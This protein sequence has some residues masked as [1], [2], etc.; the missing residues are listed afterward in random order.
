MDWYKALLS[1]VCEN[2]DRP[3]ALCSATIMY[4]QTEDIPEEE[5]AV[6]FYP[7]MLL[8]RQ[9]YVGPPD[10][11]M[12]MWKHPP[13]RKACRS[14]PAQL[15][16]A[17]HTPRSRGASSSAPAT[18]PHMSTVSSKRKPA[19]PRRRPSRAKAPPAAA[20]T[21]APATPS[22][23]P[24][25]NAPRHRPAATTATEESGSYLR[26]ASG[27]TG[28]STHDPSSTHAEVMD[29]DPAESSL[30]PQAQSS[31]GPRARQGRSIQ[32]ASVTLKQSCGCFVADN[33]RTSSRRY[34]VRLG[35]T[36]S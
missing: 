34:F 22:C 24:T 33:L 20:T 29:G 21:C 7:D 23:F 25:S 14:R 3:D 28:H 30:A 32:V 2:V 15:A 9:V 35:W 18:R 13:R 26:T 19:T 8:R 36:P 11:G 31:L 5:E 10:G 1:D 6:Y 4:A 16:Q 17:S 12:C 27:R